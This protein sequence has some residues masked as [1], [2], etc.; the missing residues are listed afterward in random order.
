[1]DNGIEVIAGLGVMCLIMGLGMYLLYRNGWMIIASKSAVTFVGSG[2]GTAASFSGCSGYIKRIVRFPEEGEYTFI[3]DSVLSKGAMTASLLGPDQKEILR[4]SRETPRAVIRLAG[5]KRYTL[6]LRFRSA[7]GRY[8][9]Q[10]DR[11]DI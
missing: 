10:W 9:L 2:R 1:M 4:L 8:R 7:T 5:K 11:V 3:L 6:L